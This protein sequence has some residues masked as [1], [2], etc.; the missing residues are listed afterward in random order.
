[1]SILMFKARMIT[2]HTLYEILFDSLVQDLRRER[3]TQARKTPQDSMSEPRFHGLH[4]TL[5]K[6]DISLNFLIR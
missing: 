5:Y 1:M 4:A 6:R 2:I 3:F